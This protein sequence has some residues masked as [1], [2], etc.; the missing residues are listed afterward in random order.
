MTL[1]KL[2]TDRET[3]RMTVVVG[4]VPTPEGGAA[5][6]N[7]IA[8]ATWRSSKLVV[9]NVAL[10]GNYAEPTFADEKDL[11]AVRNRLQRSEIEYEINQ[12]TDATDV[13]S[14]LLGVIEAEQAELVVLAI[15]R[16]SL[17]GKLLLG[18]T[19]QEV[20]RGT[21]AAILIVRP[22]QW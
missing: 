18:S 5:L 3:A 22:Q 9:V 4:Y 13:S 11:D 20:M 12:V 21:S 19:V 7:G 15:R 6:E 16:T 17:V 2:R 10:A 14:V 1:D 8:E